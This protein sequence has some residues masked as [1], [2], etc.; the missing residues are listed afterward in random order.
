MGGAGGGRQGRLHSPSLSV[1]PQA[2][3]SFRF[4]AGFIL[5]LLS[6][7]SVHLY[8]ILKTGLQRWREPGMLCLTC[9]SS[10]RFHFCLHSSLSSFCVWP[11]LRLF[12]VSV[13]S[14]DFRLASMY[15][16]VPSVSSSSSLH[17]LIGSVLPIRSFYFL[18]VPLP[19][20]SIVSFF[21]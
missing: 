17:R 3:L 5:L 12:V 6:E 16:L 15:L 4:S 11:C 10:F 19:F 20:L 13:C 8:N 7:G 14:L 21:C 2:T 1:R 18:C 9:Y